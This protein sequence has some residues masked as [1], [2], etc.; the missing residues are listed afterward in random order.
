MKFMSGRAPGNT[1]LRSARK[2]NEDGS[3][4]KI[5]SFEKNG[6]GCGASMRSACIGLIYSNN[7]TKLI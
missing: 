3:N 5:V 2:L 1:C 6:G 7:L 4:W